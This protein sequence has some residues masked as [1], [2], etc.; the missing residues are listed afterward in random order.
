[1]LVYGIIFL[2]NQNCNDEIKRCLVFI[3]GSV[4]LTSLQVLLLSSYLFPFKVQGWRISLM[5]MEETRLRQS[6]RKGE[7]FDSVDKDLMVMEET[8]AK[9]K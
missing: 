4:S 1:M 8:K 9:K 7:S 3:T 2:K 5:V 6:E